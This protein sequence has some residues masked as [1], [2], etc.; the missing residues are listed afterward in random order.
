MN[1]SDNSLTQIESDGSVV[2]IYDEDEE[3]EEK[4][5]VEWGAGEIV[6]F[7][8]KFFGLILPITLFSIPFFASAEVNND[9]L[10]FYFLL[11]ILMLVIV[12]TWR[13][14]LDVRWLLDGQITERLPPHERY[15]NLSFDFDLKDKIIEYS[16]KS[17][18]QLHPDVSVKRCL[19][20]SIYYYIIG[21][22]VFVFATELLLEAQSTGILQNQHSSFFADSNHMFVAAYVSALLGPKF[23]AIA[24]TIF[25]LSYSRADVAF[26]IASIILPGIF[27]IPAAKNLIVGIE[28]YV[29]QLRW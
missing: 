21:S 25:A 10:M 13:V 20:W 5:I 3:E 14:S 28:A 29:D 18:P 23:A 4:D 7:F 24:V 27:L 12:Q 19:T 26:I 8:A 22:F 2:L 17:S 9:F 1:D 6:V 11:N 16:F 15:P